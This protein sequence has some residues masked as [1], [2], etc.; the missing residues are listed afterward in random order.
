MYDN[1]R[2]IFKRL[3]K[4]YYDNTFEEEVESILSSYSMDREKL[5]KIISILCGVN[6]DDSD[7]YIYDLK[8]A[9]INYKT[10][11][12]KIV[13]KLPCSGN[14]S[15]DGDIICEK[16]CPVNAIFRDPKDNNIYINDELCLDC[17][18][19]VKNCPNGSI[20][21]K[22][23]FIP[24]AQLLKGQS[25]VIAAVAPAIM[26]QFGKDVTINQLRTA[27]KKLGFTDMVEVAFFADMLTLKE[28]VEYDHFVKNEQDFMI[29]SCC[30]PMWVGMLKKVYNDLV[31]YVSPSVSPMIAAGRVLKLLNPN[32][33]VVFVGPCIA[34]KAEAKEKDLIGDID[35]V[36]TF[37]EVKDIF[38]VLDV[39]PESLEED[40][41]SEYASKG[42]RLYAR[43]GGVSIAVSEAIE[44][45]FPKKYKFL[46]TI[47][48][49]GVKGCKS[50][51]DKINQKDI[52]ANFVEGMGCI[53]GCV[54]GPKVILD[55]SKGREAV[56]NFAKNSSI[57]V[58]VDS[59]CM[60][61][62][63][64]KININS[65]EDFKDKNKISIFEREFK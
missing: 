16:S 37:T 3:L 34:K 53:G 44:K 47:Q 54:G 28:A 25:I 10:S 61:D 33:K 11:Q 8:N 41:S 35:F 64:R 20:L 14:C 55:P 26:G 46:K 56:N 65:I 18:L 62:I 24:L 42:G 58:S 51:L 59:K 40:M 6:I 2:Q 27:F 60:N 39:H 15:K 29:T 31:K 12:G 38:E 5:T 52:N 32:C 49:D 43:T 57:K 9:I 36:L 23:E 17:G 7:N 22:K 48:A 50:L 63:L 1:Y 19:C 13:T 30:C 4:S 21:D 45:L